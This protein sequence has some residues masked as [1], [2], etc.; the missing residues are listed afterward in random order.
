LG[1]NTRHEDAELFATPKLRTVMIGTN[2]GE[3]G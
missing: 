1:K 3:S 2:P